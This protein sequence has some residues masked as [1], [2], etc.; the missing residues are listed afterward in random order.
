MKDFIQKIVDFF[1]S[2]YTKI[3]KLFSKT[4]TAPVVD[5]TPVIVGGPAPVV[6]P[7]QPVVVVATPPVDPVNPNANASNFG[8]GTVNTGTVNGPAPTPIV[9]PT[10]GHGGDKLDADPTKTWFG[11]TFYGP[12]QVTSVPF[13]AKGSYE[14][15]LGYDVD[16]GSITAAIA[17]VGALHGGDVIA[18]DGTYNVVLTATGSGG[19]SVFL[20]KIG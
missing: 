12:D 10:S 20:N 17:G 9:Y 4:P 8:Y 2:I 5:P 15:I 13:Q 6:T 3:V 14:V 1:K 7:S 11:A 16:R 18:L 19:S